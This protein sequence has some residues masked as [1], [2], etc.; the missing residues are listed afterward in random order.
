M[1]LDRLKS[2]FR[3]IGWSIQDAAVYDA[4]LTNG[5]SQIRSLAL[6]LRVDEPTVR[7]SLH[8]LQQH[9]LVASDTLRGQ[10]CVFA[11]DP[12]I[13]W[14]AVA[15]EMVWNS[16]STLGA[17]APEATR[18]TIGSALTP[19]QLQTDISE[20][21]SEIARVAKQAYRPG[22]QLTTHQWRQTLT[23]SETAT[24]LVEAIGEARHEIRAVS[25]GPR[26]SQVA[27]I[28][29]ALVARLTAGVLY[30][31]I[32]D[33]QEIL[34]HGL[35]IV[36]RD[37]FDAGVRLCVLEDEKLRHSFY[38]ID[39][40]YA[41]ILTKT[42]GADCICGRFTRHPN[43]VARYKNRFAR[44]RED[45]IPALFVLRRVRQISE[46]ILRVATKRGF[47]GDEV[48]WLEC[49]INWGRFCYAP[50]PSAALRER[51]SECGFTKESGRGRVVMDYNISPTD[52]RQAWE[53]LTLD[54][55]QIYEYDHN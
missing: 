14:T 10:S 48:E 18:P 55:R 52:L 33:L 24:L 6:L 23:A 35:L 21:L 5:P 30:E 19:N 49:L 28:W 44:Y 40:R 39:E 50:P 8:R 12:Q 22:S 9:L 45:A 11:T 41:V 25:F 51:S 27:H 3:T 36:E 43:I 7:Q 47:S 4:L 1:S 37:I 34:D 46:A 42:S 15:N 54:E 29:Q 53:E 13:A 16:T 17:F 38:L 2:L 31:R 20:I 26:L 32:V